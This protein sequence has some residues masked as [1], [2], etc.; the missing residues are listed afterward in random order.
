MTEQFVLD[1]K[2][3][4]NYKNLNALNRNRI[5]KDAKNDLLQ[6]YKNPGHPV[7]FSG[8]N[9]IY[10]HYNG[11]LTKKDILEI[12]SDIESYTL[13]RGYRSGQRNPTYSHFK[14]YMFQ[15]DVLFIEDFAKFNNGVKY[16]LTIID[17]FTRYAWVRQLKDKS[18]PTVLNAF[19]SVLEEAGSKPI[20][21][22][23]DRGTEFNNE[24]FTEFCLQNRIKLDNPDSSSH[25]AF[26]ER[27]NRTLQSLIY[28]YMTENKTRRFVGVLSKLVLSYDNRK[29]RMIGTSPCIA[30]NDPTS[31]LGIRMRAL[32]YHD[33][34]KKKP[35][36]YKI[37]DTVRISKL[38]TK[39]SRGY[40]PQVQEEI[41]KI[42][43]IKT[44][45]KIPMYT[46]ETL[47]GDETLIGNFY[48]YE[49]VKVKNNYDSWA[50]L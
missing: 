14:R 21:L 36:T 45:N 3:V 49:L 12:L 13:H 2:E 8:L 28:R 26:V 25:A 6:N 4:S 43:D 30:E 18:G 29:H 5:V 22:I 34:I 17:T 44:N 35:V 7:A 24:K 39:F 1:E 33:S 11:I 9:T 19:K 50:H 38:K 40:T 46:L 27:F 31:H 47:N 20:H 37:G 32:K 23:I 42:K 10:T 41:F 48:S 16:L 15:M